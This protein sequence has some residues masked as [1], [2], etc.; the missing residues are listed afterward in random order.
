MP[1]RYGSDEI[2]DTIADSD[3]L[4]RRLPHYGERFEAVKEIREATDDLST[5][6]NW[7]RMVPGDKRL[8]RVASLP[9]VVLELAL[10]HQ[11]DLLLNKQKFYAW[12]DRHPE[13]YTYH[14]RKGPR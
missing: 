13:Y 6:S 9:V 12:L 5:F 4:V 10:A 14:R 11:P 2:L 8:K 1:Y 3:E 7:G